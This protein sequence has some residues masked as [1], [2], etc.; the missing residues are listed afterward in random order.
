MTLAT[1]PLM[2]VI[3]LFAALALA[4]GSL[5]QRGGTSLPR[6]TSAI[7]GI[8]VDAVSRLP[9]AGCTVTISHLVKFRASGGAVVTTGREGDFAIRDIVD[10]DYAL[11]VSCD[12]HLPSCYRNPGAE[13]PQCDTV[14][15]VVDQQKS[16]IDFA[17]VPEAIARG[18][19]VDINGLAIPAAT[20]RL[21]TPVQDTALVT[22]RP[23]Q[24]DREGRFV[25]PGLPA[26]EWR[27]EVDLPAAADAPRPPTIYFPGVLAEADAGAIELT[28]GRMLDDI[29]VV[30]PALE[31][32]RLTVRM[33]TL[34]Q[35]L[36]KVDLALVRMDP[37]VSR[38]IMVDDTGAG[39]AAGIAPGRYVL[40]ARGYT[41]DGLTVAHDVVDY[42]GGPQEV[43]L[44]LKPP[45]RIAG[46]ITG[47][48][49]EALALDG[50][51]VG[52]A[53][54]NDSFEV[55]PLAIDEASVTAEGTFSLEGLFGTR[56]LRLFGLDPALEVKAV[57]QGRSDV[58]AGIDLVPD[59][60]TNVII[61]VGRR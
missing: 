21:G 60:E 45:A 24:T 38:R 31:E 34:E 41:H 12:G 2:S 49:G 50:V 33:V 46:R 22:T 30:A 61:V 28:A 42:L 26:G 6:G 9:I 5:D 27:L 20:V 18:R 48:K 13:P 40:S 8:V 52:A 36:E 7:S 29:V 32:N 15:V 56:Q 14:S 54:I 17:A 57:Y 1:I 16:N 23:A 4:G 25:L 39:T 43:L 55:D 51:R 59:T 58:T 53:W 11:L 44:Y 37:L 10:G 19:V 3:P 35:K 47:E